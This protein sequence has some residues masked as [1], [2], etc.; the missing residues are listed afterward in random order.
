MLE[1]K[2]I[3]LHLD[4]FYSIV[5]DLQNIDVS[6]DDED[7]AILLLCSLTPSFKHFRETLLYG[8]D[9]LCS[10]DIR[11]AL[12]QKDFMDSQFEQK[13]SIES[14]NALFV[15]KPSRNKRGMT[16]NYCRKKG[17]LKKDYWKL[18]SKQSDNYKFKKIASS[19]LVLLK[20]ILMMVLLYD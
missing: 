6:L 15:K 12:T 4:E 10:E 16:C 9:T 7:L 19:R 17:H 11:K 20:K 5:L 18:K 14:N 8:R 13:L 3:K 1:G 2:L